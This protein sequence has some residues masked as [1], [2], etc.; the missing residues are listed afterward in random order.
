M[1]VTAPL[2]LRHAV[3]KLC[4]A[5]AG[6]G[7]TPA[8]C[9]AYCTRI[10]PVSRSS[11]SVGQLPSSD[12]V[13]MKRNLRAMAFPSC[14][15]SHRGRPWR[16]VAAHRGA[17]QVASVAATTSR[18]DQATA[19]VADLADALRDLRTAAGSPTD[20]EITVR[21]ANTHIPGVIQR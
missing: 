21:A 15:A 6:E 13:P 1:R 4:A 18:P 7:G 10:S 9:K 2:T 20:W 3:L 14:T 12:V 19:T 17:R 16:T 11:Y 8:G 5:L